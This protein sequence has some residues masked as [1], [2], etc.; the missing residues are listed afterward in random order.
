MLIGSTS[1]ARRLGSTKCTTPSMAA[2]TIDL[3][4]GYVQADLFGDQLISD[5]RSDWQ[6]TIEHDGG[7]CPVCDRWGKIYGRN[8]NKTMA[9]SLI[10]LASAQPDEEGWIDVPIKA[11]RWVIRSNQLPTLK[12]WGLVERKP[13]DKDA[14]N[15]HSGMWRATEQGKRFARRD[16]MVPRRAFTYN[17]EVLGFSTDEIYIDQCFKDQFDYQEIMNLYFVNEGAQ[18]D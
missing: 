2:T 5:L 7:H 9:V 18:S 1:A 6:K 10:W 4:G 14:K 8:I 16:S 15:K 3:N 17:D 12:W 11:P 13:N